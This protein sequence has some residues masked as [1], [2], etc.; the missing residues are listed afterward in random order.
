[1]A[2]IGAAYYSGGGGNAKEWGFE[3]TWTPT[4]RFFTCVLKATWI[5]VT[6]KPLLMALPTAPT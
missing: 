1:M 2:S 3:D 6:F 5:G 4:R